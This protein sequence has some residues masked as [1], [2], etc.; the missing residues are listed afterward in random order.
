MKSIS[1]NIV[2]CVHDDESIEKLKNLTPR[3][4]QDINQRIKNIAKYTNDI[5]V[6]H[7]TD[8]SEVLQSVIDKKLNKNQMLYIRGDDMPNFPGRDIVEQYMNILFKPYKQGVSSTEIRKS[9]FNK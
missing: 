6:I 8:P 4:H 7:S 1:D 3:E 5:H 9:L 2:V